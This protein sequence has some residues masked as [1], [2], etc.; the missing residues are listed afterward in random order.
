MDHNLFVVWP[1]LSFQPLPPPKKKNSSH[2][3]ITGLGKGQAGLSVLTAV[4]KPPCQGSPLIPLKGRPSTF[5][6]F[7]SCQLL[8]SLFLADVCSQDDQSPKLLLPSQ[9]D[10]STRQLEG[11]AGTVCL[12]QPR[13]PCCPRLVHLP[14]ELLRD[15][16]AGYATT[17]LAT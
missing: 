9:M 2:F 7:I 16:L 13:P 12:V 4:G 17:L 15:H 11:V 5:Q 10:H 14:T 8:S 3:S 6:I 1:L